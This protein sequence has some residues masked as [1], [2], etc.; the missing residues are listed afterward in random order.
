MSLKIFGLEQK[1]TLR[2]YQN[3]KHVEKRDILFKN[4]Q[5]AEN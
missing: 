4:L 5:I 3:E 2:C 1:D